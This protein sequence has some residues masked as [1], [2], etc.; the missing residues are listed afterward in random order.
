M[1]RGKEEDLG[2][3][4]TAAHSGHSK[5]SVLTPGALPMM[6]WMSRSASTPVPGLYAA[7]TNLETSSSPDLKPGT[8]LSK[9]ETRSALF[10]YWPWN[11]ATP[12]TCVPSRLTY[13]FLMLYV[14][15][16]TAGVTA[17]GVAP[18]ALAIVIG[19]LRGAGMP[20]R[21]SVV[22]RTSATSAGSEKLP[23]LV[24]ARPSMRYVEND[25]PSSELAFSTLVCTKMF[26]RTTLCSM[27]ESASHDLTRF[28]ASGEGDVRSSISATDMNLPYSAV[29]GVDAASARRLSSATLRVFRLRVNPTLSVGLEAPA[30]AQ[31]SSV[32]DSDATDVTSTAEVEKA[33]ATESI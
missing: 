24:R 10:M 23:A 28:T 11:S 15:A 22:C 3:G 17:G 1:E 29:P 18:P 13:G 20:C 31:P 26:S 2:E 19:L 12:C 6:N 25:V 5:K 4:G 27:P 7:P 8:S 16:I 32:N 9:N 14:D 33:A 30:R 21:P